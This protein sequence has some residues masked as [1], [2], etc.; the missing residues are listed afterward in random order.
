MSAYFL[1]HDLIYYLESQ[2]AGYSPM[3]RI[4]V[5]LILIL[6]AF[7]IIAALM[8]YII[9]YRK[10]KRDRRMEKIRNKF[11][12]NLREVFFTKKN[13]SIEDISDKLNP[14]EKEM[15][16]EWFKRIIIDII[17][18]LKRTETEFNKLN[19]SNYNSVL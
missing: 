8:F 18:S 15:K 5:Y 17:I 4:A 13:L 1:I 7:Y 14:S 6:I 12:E 2:F 19:D 11:E 10:K 9:A 3:I 16:R